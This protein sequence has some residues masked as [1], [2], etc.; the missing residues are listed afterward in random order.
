MIG[1]NS[2]VRSIWRRVVSCR[3]AKVKV[4]FGSGDEELRVNAESF[5][6]IE[7]IEQTVC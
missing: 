7:G 4:W 6:W 3:V 1:I 5:R 2:F